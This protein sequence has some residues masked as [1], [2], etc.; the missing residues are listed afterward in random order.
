[1]MLFYI[2]T[3]VKCPMCNAEMKKITVF[4]NIIFKLPF[5]SLL[6]CISIFF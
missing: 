1:M 4:L 2:K 3:F 6:L 5:K